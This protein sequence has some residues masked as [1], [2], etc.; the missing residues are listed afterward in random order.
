MRIVHA[1]ERSVVHASK[2][3]T[4]TVFIGVVALVLLSSAGESSGKGSSSVDYS[5]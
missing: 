5:K 3:S 4:R 1:S 2:Q